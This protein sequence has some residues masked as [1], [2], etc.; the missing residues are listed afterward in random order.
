MAVGLSF[1]SE[2]GTVGVSVASYSVPVEVVG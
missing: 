2:P 1:D